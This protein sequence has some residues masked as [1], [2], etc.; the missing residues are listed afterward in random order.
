MRLFI[1]IATLCFMVAGCDRSQPAPGSAHSD[2]NTTGTTMILPGYTSENYGT[3]SDGTVIEQVT[4]RNSHGIE[5][6]VISYGGII[7][8]LLTT[9]AHGKMDN[10]VLGL[11]SLQAYVQSTSYFG[12]LIGRYG[13]RIAKGRFTLNGRDYQ[14]E[15]N[16]G[17]NHLHGGVQGFH[18]KVWQMRPFKTANS[19]G[20]VLSVTSPDGDQGYP[21]NLEVEVT[22]EL[23]NDDEL[24]VRFTATTDKTTIVNLTQHSYFNLAGKGSIL[25]HELMINAD[26]YTPVDDGLIP[27]GTIQPVSGTPFDFRQS[28]PIGRDIDITDEQLEFGLGY[29]HNFVLNNNSNSNGPDLAQRVVAE[30]YEP[31]SGRVMQMLTSE[32]GIQFYSGNFLD[33]SEGDGQRQHE[34]RSGLCLEPQHYPD[35]P[36]HPHFPTTTLEPGETYT[37]WIRYRFSTR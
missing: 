15:T 34:F 24:D 9:D 16:N 30:L 6:D 5:V 37:A 19:A 21:G 29:D 25:D 26:G 31:E 4:L 23:S 3:L 12:A 18:A 35:S 17:E 13:N 2:K 32:P 8:R 7:T 33:G 14:L 36:N 10:I 28:K 22:Y 20:V 1:V 27:D 11:D